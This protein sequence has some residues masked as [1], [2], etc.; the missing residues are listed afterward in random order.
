MISQQN[1]WQGLVAINVSGGLRGLG[2]L[3]RPRGLSWF[4]PLKHGKSL[5]L[6]H[7][8]CL[9]QVGWERFGSAVDWQSGVH[10]RH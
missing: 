10:Y 2:A 3:A 9:H 1:T 8:K 7:D 4:V 5:I 6:R